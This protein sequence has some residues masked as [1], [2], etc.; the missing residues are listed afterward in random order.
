MIKIDPIQKIKLCDIC[1]QPGDT[2]LMTTRPFPFPLKLNGSNLS[3]DRCLNFYGNEKIADAVIDALQEILDIFGLDFI[4]ENGLDWYGGCYCNRKS[5]GSD[6]KSVHAWGM[7]VDYLP[8][9]GAYGKPS[10]IPYHVVQAFKN[11]GFIW[12]GDWNH[13]DGMHFSGVIE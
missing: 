10:L 13:P 9:L 5:R 8:Q 2:F 4:Q 6:Y 1:G 12:G 3:R 7:A 11:R